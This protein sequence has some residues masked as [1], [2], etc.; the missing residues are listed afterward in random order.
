MPDAKTGEQ[1]FTL[2]CLSL[3]LPG[4]KSITGIPILR[5]SCINGIPDA[6]ASITTVSGFQ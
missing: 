2:E 5:N 4:T 6:F 3:P 1:A